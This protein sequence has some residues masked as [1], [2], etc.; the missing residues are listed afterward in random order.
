MAAIDQLFSYATWRDTKVSVIV[1]NKENK[2]LENVLDSI[3]GVL[4]VHA[5][6]VKNVKQGQWYCEIQSAEDERVMHVTVQA[7]NL[8]V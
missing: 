5:I 2:N 1:F 8:H 6:R 4:N 7:F 3:Q